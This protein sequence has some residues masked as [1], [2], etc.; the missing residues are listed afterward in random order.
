MAKRNYINENALSFILLI[1]SDAYLEHIGEYTRGKEA[2]LYDLSHQIMFVR[3]S[4]NVW[5]TADMNQVLAL[6]FLMGLPMEKYER[7]IRS[8]EKDEEILSTKLPLLI[9][10]KRMNRD[11]VVEGIYMVLSTKWKQPQMPRRNNQLRTERISIC[12]TCGEKGHTAENYVQHTDE[13]KE[14]GEWSADE[15]EAREIH[16][17]GASVKEYS[18]VSS[19]QP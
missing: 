16:K 3:E 13:N 7:F 8:L 1:V 19:N 12:Y 2:W 17:S 14:R 11:A 9:E 4:M 6:I 10:E 5:T 18:C 15:D